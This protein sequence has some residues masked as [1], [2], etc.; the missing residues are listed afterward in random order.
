MNEIQT[1]SENMKTTVD[2]STSKIGAFEGTL[3][4][5]SDSST[6]IV[7]YS[8]HMENS[9]F[10]VLAKID[11]IL[12]K[13]RAYNSI[14]SLK[15]ILKAQ[16][17]HECSLGEWY[18]NEGKRRFSYTDSYARISKPHSIVHQNA[19][20]NL[21]QLEGDADLNT[22]KDADRIISNFELMEEASDELFTLMDRMLDESKVSS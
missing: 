4:E 15:P 17:T 19:N 3:E 10:I 2:A 7:D 8:Y 16:S 12:Y 6:K 9:V 13:S 5:L 14:I 21:K 1:S 18:D 20:E 22:L 11:H